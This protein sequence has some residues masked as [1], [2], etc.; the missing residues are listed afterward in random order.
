M[1]AAL[2]FGKLPEQNL[3]ATKDFS[4]PKF[5]IEQ[6]G[7]DPERQ[8]DQLNQ[9][10]K[11]R[12]AVYEADTERH[13]SRFNA[14]EKARETLSG[15]HEAL[16]RLFDPGAWGS[17]S[18]TFPPE[19]DG[20]VEIH[21]SGPAQS[22]DLQ[23]YRVVQPSFLE[24]TA[25]AASSRFAPLGLPAG[26]LSIAGCDLPV[27][28]STS[29]ATLQDAFDAHVELK[30]KGISPLILRVDERTEG[31]SN[32]KLSVALPFGEKTLAIT[33]DQDGAIVKALGLEQT[34][35]EE[36][37]AHT[38]NTALFSINGVQ[39]ERPS[40]DISDIL[41]GV[42]LVLKKPTSGEHPSHID[43][44]PRTELIRTFLMGFAQTVVAYQQVLK[45][46]SELGDKAIFDR[47]PFVEQVMQDFSLFLARHQSAKTKTFCGLKEMAGITVLDP[48]AFDRE[49]ENFTAL[50]A[51]FFGEASEDRPNAGAFKGLLDTLK[52]KVDRLEE[53]KEKEADAMRALQKKA[54]K[55][56]EDIDKKKERMHTQHA[57]LQQRAMEGEI[58]QKLQEGLID[59]LFNK[60][61]SGRGK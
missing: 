6:T 49:A 41:P 45:D 4:Y 50:E 8:C 9:P 24:T 5:F 2:P 31:E 12:H 53:E 19:A 58:L 33:D 14:L 22:F 1:P 55:L 54:T 48:D 15:A 52:A 26:T 10:L 35:A 29:L 32:F 28:A 40:N 30:E 20:C 46:D 47:Y 7:V 23:V 51:C 56:Q 57:R 3:F 43:I 38:P 44:K 61:K 21:S 11:A 34:E 17:F 39:M 59:R 13:L 25:F 42:R 60:D 27:D 16:E 18:A 36:E 37:G